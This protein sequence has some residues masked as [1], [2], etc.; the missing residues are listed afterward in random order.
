MNA[1][2]YHFTLGDLR[3]TVV[4]DGQTGLPPH[5]LYATNATP[6]EVEKTLER[7]CLPTDV[8]LLQCNAIIVRSSGRTVLIDTGAGHTLG[9]DLGFLPS[10]LRNAGVAPETID[11]VVLT[12]GHLDHVGGITK[13]DG[14]LTYPNA[15]FYIH[16]AEWR[17][18]LSDEVDL[19][20]MAVEEGFRDN[21]RQA[22]RE[23]LSAIKGCVQ[24]FTYG[25][26]ILPF[27]ETVAAPGHTPGHTALLIGSGEHTLLHLADVI[28]HPAFD[29][30]HPS[31]RTA[32]DQDAGEAH[33]TRLS[34]LDKAAQERALLTAYHLPFPALGHIRKEGSAYDWDAIPWRFEGVSK[35]SRD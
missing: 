30:E 23:N 5:P 17:F 9:E 2:H 18:W 4:G 25:E 27:V 16:E 3:L 22:A 32:F 34:L 8:Y 10:H 13:G 1:S 26:Q 15:Q 14:S 6:E 29:L 31:W 24:T 21:F 35:S 28:H 19:L 7:H 11:T 33:R 12:H 20:S